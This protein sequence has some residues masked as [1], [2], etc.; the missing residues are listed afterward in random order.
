MALKSLTMC[1]GGTPETFKYCFLGIPQNSIVCVSTIGCN[2][3]NE[4]D[5]RRFGAGLEIMVETLKP[6]HILMYGNAGRNI[7][8]TVP[9]EMLQCLKKMYQCR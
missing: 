5:E 9:K 3:K 6:R 2:V 8:T 4:H 7:F 1:A